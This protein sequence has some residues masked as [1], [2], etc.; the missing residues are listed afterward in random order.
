MSERNLSD[1]KFFNAD[2]AAQ[3]LVALDPEVKEELLREFGRSA[4]PAVFLLHEVKLALAWADVLFLPFDPAFA[5][6]II[7]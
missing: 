4:F 5:I 2:Q 3:K 1:A 6:A 7:D